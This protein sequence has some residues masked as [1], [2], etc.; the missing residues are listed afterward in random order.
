M[1]F[2]CLLLVC[3]VMVVICLGCVEVRCG[4]D[5]CVEVGDDG[6]VVV[7]EKDKNSVVVVLD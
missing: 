2:V 5:V 7:L 1:F 3:G 6:V 4:Y